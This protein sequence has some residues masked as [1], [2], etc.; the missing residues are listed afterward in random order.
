MGTF[1]SFRWLPTV[2]AATMLAA[3]VTLIAVGVGDAASNAP[4]SLTPIVPCRLVDTRASDQ[5]GPRGT[6][7]SADT[8]VIFAV[9]GTNGECVI[10]TSATGIA[11]NVTAVGPTAAS[12]LTLY[13]SDAAERPKA[14]NLNF[15]PGT[16]PTPNQVTVGLS[17]TGEVSVYNLAGS[18]DVII[19]V[20]GYYSALPAA[21]V[22]PSPT[23]IHRTATSTSLHGACGG[24]PNYA[25]TVNVP[26]GTW[27]A[28]Y[29]I[30]SVNFTGVSDLFRC[31]MET[32]DGSSGVLAL[33]TVRIGGSFPT[34]DVSPHSGQAPLTLGAATNVRIACSHDFN[35][36]GGVGLLANAYMENANLSLLKIA[37]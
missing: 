24:C 29:S 31:W 6:P 15:F 9:W 13:P 21:P 23:V 1:T 8:P 26:A 25:A 10:P 2:I 22:I 4:S 17:A 19:D 28:T 34:P 20:V 7:L 33:T 36:G 12:F 18:V 3:T 14:S 11:A 32:S 30:T 5:V 27:L 35:I 16:P 37:P